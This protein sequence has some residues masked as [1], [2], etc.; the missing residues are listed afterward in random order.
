M[1]LPLWRAARLG[2]HLGYGVAAA[3]VVLPWLGESQRAALIRRWS[4]HILHILDV[5]LQAEG[6]LPTADPRPALF[7]ANHVSWL[8]IW[9]INAVRPVRFVAKSEVRRWPIIGWLSERAGALFIER[10]RRHDVARVSSAGAEALR[11]GHSV[12]VFAEGTTSDGT[13]LYPFKSALLQSA[14]EA[15]TPVWPVALRYHDEAGR[16]NTAVAYAGETT[17]VQSLRAVLAQRETVVRLIF[18]EPISVTGRDR[19]ALAQ[20]AQDAIATLA[21]LPVHV[22]PERPADPR[23]GLP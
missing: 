2:L 14:V 7:V 4:A 22:A 10:G 1:I 3:A 5:R 18:A 16:P 11:G 6:M 17:L 15:G 13:R 9:A 12:C 21:R 20:A 8:D 19:R 23:D